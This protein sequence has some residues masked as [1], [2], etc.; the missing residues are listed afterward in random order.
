MATGAT[1][2]EIAAALFVSES[3]SVEGGGDGAATGSARGLPLAQ[4]GPDGGEPPRAQPEPGPFAPL[5]ALDQS[6]A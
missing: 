5:L 2:A 6:G 1:N 3:A 4:G